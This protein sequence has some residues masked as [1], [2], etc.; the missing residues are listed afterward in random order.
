MKRLKQRAATA[1]IRL[2]L[3]MQYAYRDFAGPQP[4][5]AVAVL[6]CAHD[7][8]FDTIDTWTPLA[9]IQASD[10]AHLRTLFMF[11]QTIATHMS[12]LGNRVVATAIAER[13][14]S[15]RN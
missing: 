5:P 8:G 9:A 6:N 10:P 3:V 1:S 15:P 4:P 11:H 12:A 2:M 13:L 7:F 14:A